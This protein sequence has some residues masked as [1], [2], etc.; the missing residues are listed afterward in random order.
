[1]VILDN[2]SDQHEGVVFHYTTQKG[3]LGIVS[4]KTIWATDIRYLNDA[5][6]L[7]L[8]ADLARAE[9][10]NIK[11]ASTHNDQPLLQLLDHELSLA[12]RRYET[13]IYVCSLSSEKDLLSQWRGYCPQGNGFSVGFDFAQ[14]EDIAWEQN[15]TLTKCI[16]D[17]G[18][19]NEI[20]RDFLQQSIASLHKMSGANSTNLDLAASMIGLNFQQIA[21]IIK[22]AKF[23]EEQEWRLISKPIDFNDPRIR[24]RE[25]RSMI[26]PY[27][28]LKL[29]R[30][31]ESLNIRE[32]I[33]GPTPHRNLA[34]IAVNN[35]LWSNHIECPSIQRSEI[36]YRVW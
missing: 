2:S 8:A 23:S 20:L 16:Y 9:L 29:A 1:M 18:K 11:K 22:H 24:F 32:I 33:I 34:S 12:A 10:D 5:A 27:Y 14:L 25:G 21:P 13:S 6:E 28:E 31:N 26:I 19:Q 30:D 7:E 35:L 17:E 36:P 4:S 3:L 15:F